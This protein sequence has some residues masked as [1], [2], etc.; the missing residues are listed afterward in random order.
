MAESKSSTES[1]I[2]GLR[3]DA[4][5]TSFDHVTSL[6][7]FGR[8]WYASGVEAG[9]AQDREARAKLAQDLVTRNDE[10][11]EKV[12]KLTFRVNMLEA[13]NRELREKKDKDLYEKEK[14]LQEKAV[15]IK[16]NEKEIQILKTAAMYGRD[17]L[18]Y[19][20]DSLCAIG[21]TYQNRGHIGLLHEELQRTM[22]QILYSRDVC[23]T[24]ID[25]A[26][27]ESKK[28]SSETQASDGFIS[29]KRIKND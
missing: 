16:G 25:S 22:K 24:S 19:A 12:K 15:E 9:L 13:K 23:T 26:A 28:R 20:A 14:L 18:A 21:T 8:K 1:E 17:S 6:E 27:Q 4:H 3:A 2:P 10:L 29:N 7:Q 5:A 11:N